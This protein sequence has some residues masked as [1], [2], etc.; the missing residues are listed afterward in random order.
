MG[1]RPAG[2]EVGASAL[3]NAQGPLPSHL[4]W[5]QRPLSPCFELAGPGG[6][7]TESGWERADSPSPSSAGP[8]G[9]GHCLGETP[10]NRLMPAQ[11]AQPPPPSRE[12]PSTFSS[13]S[14]SSGPLATPFKKGPR[15]GSCCFSGAQ[16]FP[17]LPGPIQVHES[18]SEAVSRGQ[19][20]FRRQQCGELCVPQRGMGGR[21][22]IWGLKCQA[23]GQE[24]GTG[25]G[26]PFR[27]ASGVHQG[28]GRGGEVR[29]LGPAPPRAAG[30][31]T[32]R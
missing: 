28:Q 30:S 7:A 8:S 23:W 32:G 27:G 22:Q 21:N 4:L 14:P 16:L 19:I 31:R 9:S 6:G 15:R 5:H 10:G 3:A 26:A 20:T 29:T 13:H 2:R 11:V 18:A 24:R 12:N 17:G 1:T 25:R